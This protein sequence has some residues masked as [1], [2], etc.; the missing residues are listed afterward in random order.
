M[1]TLLS[2]DFLMGTDNPSM[3][4]ADGEGPVRQIHLDS[5]RISE[6]AVSNFDFS[7]FVEDT[8]YITEAE[9][10]GWS[11]VFKLLVPKQTTKTVESAAAGTEWW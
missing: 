9:R 7:L 10:F 1:I 4:A 3:V 11:F 6:C 8:D 2:D 5:F